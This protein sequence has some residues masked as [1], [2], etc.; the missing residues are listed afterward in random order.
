M[1]N[2]DSEDP[3]FLRLS[4]DSHKL[5]EPNQQDS[6]LESPKFNQQDFIS[7]QSGSSE[8]YG[9]RLLKVNLELRH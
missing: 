9:F 1:S 6:P 8:N 3:P 4:T 2:I 5:L 7:P